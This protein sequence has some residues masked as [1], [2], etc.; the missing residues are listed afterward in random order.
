MSTLRDIRTRLRSVENIKKI[1]DAM[2]KVAAVQL[3]RAQGKAEQS[4]PYISKIKEIIEKLSTTDSMHPLFEH[5]EVQ[6]TGLVIISADRGLSGSYNTNILTTADNFLKKY[7][8]DNVE[9]ILIGKKALEYYRS[10]KWPIRH[11]VTGW[12]GKLS[13]HQIKIF[14]TQLVHWFLERDFDEIWLIY[15]H[16]I[17]LMNRKVILEKFLNLKKPKAEEKKTGLNNYIFEPSVDEILTEILPQYCVTRIQTALNEAFA[18]EL[19]ARVM[20]MQIASKNST[21]L[22]ERLTLVKNRVR[23]EAITKEMLEISS[24]A[25]R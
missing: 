6:K 19:A 12:G 10:K 7:T 25:E 4:R 21:D 3:R 22:I 24:G 13:F 8:P 18:S 14:A 20:A 15:T 1:T 5:R 2:E 17:T 16:N 11:E 23:Q 9:L